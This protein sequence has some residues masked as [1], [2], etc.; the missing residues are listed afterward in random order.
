MLVPQRLWRLPLYTVNHIL[1][2]SSNSIITLFIHIWKAIETCNSLYLI[3]W[4]CAQGRCI[5][6]YCKAMT[7]IHS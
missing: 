6:S 1:P 3:S 5:I 7:M 4:V 2:I